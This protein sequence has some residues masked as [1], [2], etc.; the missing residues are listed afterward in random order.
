MV[1]KFTEVQEFQFPFEKLRLSQEARALIRGVY[2]L[3]RPFPADEKLGLTSQI[4]RAA[5][6]VPTNFADGYGRTSLKD[7]AYFS[8][9][10]YASFLETANLLIIA[11]DQGFVFPADLRIQR[12]QSAPLCNQINPLRKCQVAHAA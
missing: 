8:R 3:T 5:I 12:D 4:S 1:E 6:S 7:Q 9:I 10:T 11:A 2:P